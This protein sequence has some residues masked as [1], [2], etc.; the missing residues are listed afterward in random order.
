MTPE[1]LIDG[2]NAFPEILRQIGCAQRS[3]EVHMFI[4]RDDG[5]GRKI[6]GALVSAADRGVRVQIVKDRYGV[7]CE[8]SEENRASFFHRGLTPA[9]RFSVFWLT[10]GYNTDQLLWRGRRLGKDLERA[11][12]AHPN[13]SVLDADYLSD[14]SKYWIFDDKVLIFGGINIEDKENGTDRKGRAYRDYMVMLDDREA[15]RH[16][17]DQTGGIFVRNVKSPVR[18][19]EVEQKMLSLIRDSERSLTIVMAYFSPIPAFLSSIEDAV[20]RGVR[21]RILVPAKANYMDAANKDAMRRLFPLTGQGLTIFLSPRMIHAKVIMSEKELTVGSCNITKKAFRQL[22]E[23]NL[24]R[25]CESDNFTRAL[26]ESVE[27]TIAEAVPV[28]KARQLRYS[29]LYAVIE[30]QFM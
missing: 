14:H 17:A 4:W 24:F 22:D 3:I 12:R 18:S 23:L 9:E 21:V 10:V 8:R 25:K 2:K 1:L 13:I 5:I 20:R 19:F 27:E 30:E 6:A 11:L 29:R 16:F 15:V 7:V 26:E 28:T